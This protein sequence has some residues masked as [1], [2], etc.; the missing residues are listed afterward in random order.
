MPNEFT[1][2]RTEQAGENCRRVTVK[3]GV[4]LYAQLGS[5]IAKQPLAKKMEQ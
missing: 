2:G 1:I 5:P 4:K 3:N